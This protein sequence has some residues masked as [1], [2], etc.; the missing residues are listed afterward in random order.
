MNLNPKPKRDL[1][2]QEELGVSST[3]SFFMSNE[4]IELLRRYLVDKKETG[5]G[6][7]PEMC[8]MLTLE[9]RKIH[10]KKT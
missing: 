8:N 3:M 9:G 6:L 1:G 4:Q 7:F 5:S 10:Q 2:D